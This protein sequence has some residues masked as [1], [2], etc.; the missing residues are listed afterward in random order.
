MRVIGFALLAPLA[1]ACV[2]GSFTVDLPEERR[3]QWEQAVQ[4]LEAATGLERPWSYGSCK[5]H[6]AGCVTVCNPGSKGAES[7]TYYRWICLSPEAVPQYS[8]AYLTHEL[9]HTY[10]VEKHSTDPES[11]M[12]AKYHLDSRLVES[13]LINICNRNDCSKFQEEK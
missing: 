9:V 8:A 10:G 11:I 1:V 2:P 5:K 4:R 7:D 12:Q 6:E 3:A 13:D